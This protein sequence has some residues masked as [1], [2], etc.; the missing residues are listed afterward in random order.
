MQVQ[1]A[2]GIHA[3]ASLLLSLL[4]YPFPLNRKCSSSH[5][6]DRVIGCFIALSLYLFPLFWT[7]WR[8]GGYDDMTKEHVSFS[9]AFETAGGST[10]S[11]H[12]KFGYTL[13][14]YE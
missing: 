6:R 8:K 5:I 2:V 4:I 11:I 10:S 3:L 9:L 13:W 12:S 1:V 14:R 7:V